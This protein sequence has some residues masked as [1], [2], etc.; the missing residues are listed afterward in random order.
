MWNF[1]CEEGR[2]R[3]KSDPE[4][5]HGLP[6]HARDHITMPRGTVEGTR[7]LG[8]THAHHPRPLSPSVVANQAALIGV[9]SPAPLQDKTAADSACN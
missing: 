4:H 7:L 1:G 9:P 8:C 5:W 6:M 3:A 2:D